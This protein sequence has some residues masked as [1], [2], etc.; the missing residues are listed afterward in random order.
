MIHEYLTAFHYDYQLTTWLPVESYIRCAI[1]WVWNGF[2]N[3]FFW[4]NARSVCVKR[5]HSFKCL[6]AGLGWCKFLFIRYIMTIASFVSLIY[7]GHF[8]RYNDNYTMS[9]LWQTSLSIFWILCRFIHQRLTK[10][11][12]LIQIIFVIYP[13]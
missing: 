13:L 2:V 8:F 3:F 4:Q 7:R 11:C 10:L 5:L 1:I 12:T 6:W 9:H